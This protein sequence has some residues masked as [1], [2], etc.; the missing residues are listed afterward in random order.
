MSESPP[1][2]LIELMGR[3][4]LASAEQVRGMRGRVRQ[5]THGLPAFESVWVDALAQ[6]RLLTAYQA[7]ELNEGRGAS[8]E[9]GPYVLYQPLPSPGYAKVFRA[10]EIGLRPFAEKTLGIQ[11]ILRVNPRPVTVDD[12]TS[13][14]EAAW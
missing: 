3:F 14:F 9:V 10:R 6:A 13:I 11:R 2:K 12:V 8:L 5:L 1:K 7:V 4:G